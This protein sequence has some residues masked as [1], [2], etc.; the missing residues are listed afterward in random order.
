MSS[1]CYPSRKKTIYNMN[2]NRLLNVML[3]ISASFCIL[4]LLA[5]LLLTVMLIHWHI[6]RDF[7]S[8]FPLTILDQ[9]AFFKFT[10]TE[11]ASIGETIRYTPTTL[12]NMSRW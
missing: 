2:R 4:L 3:F 11:T 12:S 10:R 6:D 9:N 8:Q 7:Y 1:S 5:Q